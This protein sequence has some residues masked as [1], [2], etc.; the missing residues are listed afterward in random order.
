MTS[1]QV[2]CLCVRHQDDKKTLLEAFHCRGALLFLIGPTRGTSDVKTVYN[3]IY[4]GVYDGILIDFFW[5]GNLEYT[6]TSVVRQ[7]TSH[8]SV[9]ALF[10]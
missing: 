5:E 8:Y 7:T 4:K 2:Q 9:K 1:R 3:E 6:L 10:V